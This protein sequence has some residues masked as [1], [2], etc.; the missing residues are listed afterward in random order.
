MNINPKSAFVLLHKLREAM[1]ATLGGDELAG[2]VEVDGAYFGKRIRH[3]R[4][5]KPIGRTAAR[6]ISSARSWLSLA[7][8][9]GDARTWVVGKEGDAVP[10]IRADTSPREPKFMPT[11]RAHGT[12]YTPA[13]R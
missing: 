8:G 2:E 7:S 11:N 10:M 3:R 1:G 4:T 9:G 12:S 5:G 6:S 13:T